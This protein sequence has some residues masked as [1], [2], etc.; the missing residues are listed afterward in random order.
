MLKTAYRLEKDWMAK[1][2]VK[3]QEFMKEKFAM[4]FFQSWG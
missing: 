4:K 1:Q 2:H 3:K